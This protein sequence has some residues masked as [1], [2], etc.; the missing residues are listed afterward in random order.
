MRKARILIVDDDPSLV[1]LLT[2]TLE[3]FDRYEVASEVDPNRALEAVLEFRPHLVILDWIMSENPG[4]E[5]CEQI[6]ADPRVAGTP[7]I[8][9]TAFILK[10]DGPQ[11]IAG[12]PALAKPFG[13][14]ELVGLI[15][16][17]LRGIDLETSY[18]SR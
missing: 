11:E 4:N 10:R 14:D 2:L 1:R 6:R 9:L 8:F 18:I 5:V 13:R 17:Q 7:I 16:A 3:R 15:E 12:C